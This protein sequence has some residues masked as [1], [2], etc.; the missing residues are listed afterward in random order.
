MAELTEKYGSD[1]VQAELEAGSG[2]VF[3][4]RLDGE[5]IYSKKATGR[6][7]G[8]AEIPLFIDQILINR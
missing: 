3:E 8:Y 2:G 4:V 1:T 6:F 5:V 7:P